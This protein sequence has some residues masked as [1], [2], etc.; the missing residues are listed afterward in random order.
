M[1]LFRAL[2]PQREFDPLT[3]MVKKSQKQSSEAFLL[4]NV[5]GD[6]RESGKLTQI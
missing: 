1:D 4:R 5:R 2:L 6:D 3:G